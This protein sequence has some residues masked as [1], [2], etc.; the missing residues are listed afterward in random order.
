MKRFTL[1]FLF[2]ISIPLS[3]L[4][5]MKPEIMKINDTLYMAIFK[6]ETDEIIAERIKATD[7]LQLDSLVKT[8]NIEK[9]NNDSK[10][11]KAQREYTIK[12][13]IGTPIPDFEAP[14]TLGL[15]HHPSHYLGR[16]LLLHFWNFWDAS[17]EN[18]IPILNRMVEK[19]RKDGLEI[20][21]F[22]DIKITAS[23]EKILK[24]SPIDFPLIPNAGLFAR[25]FLKIDTYTPYLVI[26]DKR[27]N[28]R[29]FFVN[30]ELN[31]GNNFEAYQKFANDLEGKI[32]SLLKE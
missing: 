9:L 23:E 21:S 18:E 6:L 15:K 17:F 19:Y 14:D 16:V 27:G 7:S 13:L 22:T 1:A 25:R 11:R 28:F 24:R 12:A 8:F 5:Q 32:S 20:L 10:K 4:G 2:F 3:I 31:W 30:N 26:V 29:H